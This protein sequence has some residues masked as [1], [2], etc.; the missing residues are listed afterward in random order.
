MHLESISEMLA[1]TVTLHYWALITEASHV[2]FHGRQKCV[3]NSVSQTNSTFVCKRI[4]IC[5][6]YQR[7][8]LSM[9]PKHNIIGIKKQDIFLFQKLNLQR[10]PGLLKM[11]GQERTWMWIAVG[12]ERG[13]HHRKK[14]R[15]VQGHEHRTALEDG[16]PVGVLSRGVM[17]HHLHP[18]VFLCLFTVSYHYISAFNRAL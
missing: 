11:E 7:M 6:N 10:W 14:E 16:E 2:S 18:A 15:P 13:Q 8:I 3:Q 1:V 4:F 12:V 17:W 5:K 9:P